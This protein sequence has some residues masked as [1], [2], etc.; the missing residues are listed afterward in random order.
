MVDVISEAQLA[1]WRA[2]RGKKEPM[3]VKSGP[4]VEAMPHIDLETV[5]ETV[6]VLRLMGE[7]TLLGPYN[8]KERDEDKGR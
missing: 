4:N 1:E 2:K 3:P 8:Q 6:R 5:Q 7:T